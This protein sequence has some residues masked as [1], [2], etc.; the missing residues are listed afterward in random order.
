[1]IVI[2]FLTGFANVQCRLFEVR[3]GPLANEMPRARKFL[4]MVPS[5]S[6]DWPSVLKGRVLGI[7]L[8]GDVD[9]SRITVTP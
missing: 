9:G 7:P 4:S 2:S 1:V 6:L 3:A 8:I 5:H